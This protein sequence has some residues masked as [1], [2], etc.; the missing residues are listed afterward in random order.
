MKTCSK[1]KKTKELKD[2][3]KDKNSLDGLCYSC[4]SCRAT[5]RKVYNKAA[6]EKVD[7]YN[8]EYQQKHKNNLAEKRKL[9][10]SKNPEKY[11]KRY[12]NW[13]S[14]NKHIEREKSA[15]RR[16]RTKKQTP[17]W[18][19]KKDIRNFYK[20]CPANYHVDHIVPLKGKNVS[21]LHCLKN[22]QYLKAEANLRKGNRYES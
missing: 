5:Y 9:D 21:G 11:K 7:K 15:A 2:F 22:L 1:C 14:Q 8:K 16:V 17:I 20:D 13:S 4:R 18:A 3:C 6:K 19:R 10:R 12:S